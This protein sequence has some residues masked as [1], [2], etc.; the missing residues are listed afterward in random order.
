MT[1]KTTDVRYGFFGD[2]TLFQWGEFVAA[3]GLTLPWKV[4]CDVLAEADW[5]WAARIVSERIAFGAVE[6]VPEGG[7][8]FAAALQK[9]CS[10]GHGLL[11]VDDVLTTGKSITKHRSSRNAMGFVLF[12]RDDTGPEWVNAIWRMT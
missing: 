2:G 1:D 8:Q 6:G 3:S 5:E 10:P 7:L 4:E 12:A 9:Y 11:I